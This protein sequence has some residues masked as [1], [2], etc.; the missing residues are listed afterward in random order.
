LAPGQAGSI[1]GPGTVHDDPDV[2]ALG[3]IPNFVGRVMRAEAEQL[4]ESIK[5]SVGLLRRHL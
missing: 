3:H 5:Q 4:V 1:K 2:R